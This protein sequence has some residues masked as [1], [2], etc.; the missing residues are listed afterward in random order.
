MLVRGKPFQSSLMF[1]SKSRA[2]PSGAP[3]YRV[4][5]WPHPQTLARPEKDGQRKALAYWT[6][7]QITVSKSLMTL[8]PA[9]VLMLLAC[10]M[11]VI[12][13]DITP[14]CCSS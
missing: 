6:C 11:K 10:H 1:A 5:S 9:V 14:T 12:I 13:A 2:Y 8:A 4:G 3:P 7:S